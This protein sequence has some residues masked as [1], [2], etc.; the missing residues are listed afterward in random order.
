VPRSRRPL[1]GEQASAEY[2]VNLLGLRKRL[3]TVEL[4]ASKEKHGRAPRV[5]GSTQEK[6]ADT[7][8]RGMP[9][10]E[11]PSNI[12]ASCCQYDALCL[13]RLACRSGHRHPSG[14]EVLSDLLQTQPHPA[15]YRPQ[16]QVQKVGYLHVSVP[17]EVRE[18]QYLELLRR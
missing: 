7:V 10:S 12:I 5:R 11:A 15:F 6:I 14:V 9:N 16:R 1:Q 17:R 3:V 2:Y 8:E 13:L 4:A 18:L